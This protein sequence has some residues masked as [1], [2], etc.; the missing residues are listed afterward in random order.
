MPALQSAIEIVCLIVVKIGN[1]CLW[2]SSFYEY[3]SEKR[4]ANYKSY[5]HSEYAINLKNFSGNDKKTS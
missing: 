2:Q 1:S 3:F 4:K 5:V